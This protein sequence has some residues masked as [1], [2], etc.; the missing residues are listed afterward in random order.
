MSDARPNI[1]LVAAFMDPGDPTVWSRTLHNLTGQLD[2]LGF[3]GGYRDATPW[4]PATKAVHWWLGATGRRIEV[5]QLRAEMR[6][7][8]SIANAVGRLRTA[9]TDDCFIVPPGVFGRPVSG[10]YV[11]W[12]EISPAQLRAAY[13]T[14]TAS[15]GFPGMTPR[16]LESLLRQQLR[17]FHHAHACCV[18]SEWAARSLADDHGIDPTIVKVVGYGRNLDVT[19]PP[20]RDWSTPTF[21]FI[22][23]EWKRKNGDAVVRAFTRLRREVP[24]AELHVEG[25]HPPLDVDGVHAYGRLD[26]ER[27]RGR[28]EELFR[29]ATCFVVP[30]LLESFGIVY[31]EAAAAGLPSIGTAN[32]GTATSIGDG[33]LR[34]DPHDDE[35]LLAAMRQMADPVQAQEMGRRALA[36]AEL[37][38]WRKSAERVV[39]AFAPVLADKAGFADFL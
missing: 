17:V 16:G 28:L 35:A 21:L 25:N 12:G 2:A 37:F 31:V 23:A 30:S 4:A 20:G 19:P 13:P 29:Q 9:A 22:G 6:A 36:R 15:V 11:T 32:G 1:H 5:W 10:R 39:R 14:Y 26:F 33:G 18:A 27:D 3:Y 8:T 34:V 38:T 7:V 24:A